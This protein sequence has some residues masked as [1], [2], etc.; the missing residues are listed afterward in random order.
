MEDPGTAIPEVGGGSDAGVTQPRGVDAEAGSEA[1]TMLPTYREPA[2]SLRVGEVVDRYK[3]IGHLATTYMSETYIVEHTETGAVE[4][5]KLR[6][7]D[8]RGD[9]VRRQFRHEMRL[10]AS[11]RKSEH[12]IAA[13]Y[14]GEVNIGG[15]M[16]PF[17]ITEYVGGGRSLTNF[18]NAQRLGA[19]E[20]LELFVKVCVAVQALHTNDKSL[21]HRDLKPGNILVDPSGNPRLIDLG[22]ALADSSPFADEWRRAAQTHGYGSPEQQQGDPSLVDQRAD[23]YALGEV[24]RVLMLPCGP[25]APAL[26]RVVRIAKSQ[27]REDRY[28][29]VDGEDPSESLGAAVRA[30]LARRPVPERDGRV[31][32]GS[33]VS[34]WLVRRAWVAV[35]AA[36]VLAM[37][38]QLFVL[39]PAMY[40]HTGINAWYERM[41]P[42]SLAW[43][44]TLR[45]LPGVQVVAIT[46]QTEGKLAARP[47]EGARVEPVGE[48]GTLRH[49]HAA[50]LREIARVRPR[51][52]IFDMRQPIEVDALEAEIA[53]LRARGIGVAF[54]RD[55]WML[56][57][58]PS[59]TVGHAVGAATAF[60]EPAFPTLL[61]DLVGMN[62]Q[63]RTALSLA[64]Y[65]WA[66]SH[67][68]AAEFDTMWDHN[69]HML[70][71]EA[72]E[73]VR[74]VGRRKIGSR[75]LRLTGAEVATDAM[76]SEGVEVAELLGYVE[77]PLPPDEGVFLAS[78]VDYADVVHA[79]SPSLET[80]V[81][82]VI[83][84][85]RGHRDWHVLPDGREVP[86]GY[87]QAWAISSS[88]SEQVLWRPS[89]LET[90]TISAGVAVAGGVLALFFPVGRVR[91]RVVVWAATVGGV[92]ATLAAVA[93]WSTTRGGYVLN[94]II[95]VAGASLG[96]VCVFLVR[97]PARAADFTFPG[98]EV[99]AHHGKE[100]PA[101]AVGS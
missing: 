24:L 74:G 18:A 2:T 51:A 87:I 37:L 28:A 101:G 65:A 77:L 40:R 34:S 35:P 15:V 27:R 55:S 31:G 4:V 88:L 46:E 54:T 36:V 73:Y 84:A 17:M 75:G 79:R 29:C 22:I 33:R 98:E 19:R 20:R 82:V 86:G 60:F 11:L 32:A 14:A 81:A 50:L 5:L 97:L 67:L 7:V 41:F 6:K 76:A 90:Y 99:G 23:V 39:A 71:V 44:N 26:A 9:E 58:M 45:T 64:G 47:V 91:R 1:G 16:T 12:Y 42:P 38:L 72:W 57:T 66:M 21:V 13:K 61:V 83:D 93:L 56:N 96:L 3:V 8:G 49:D 94:P 100:A 85:R 10:L 80:R 89:S 68:G 59:P 78:T 63:G 92:M 70:R 53:A 62:P 43:V 48:A 25:M 69:S 30:L 52:V 95:L